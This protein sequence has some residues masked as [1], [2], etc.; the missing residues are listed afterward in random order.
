MTVDKSI[1]VTYHRNMCSRCHVWR[2][3]NVLVFYGEVC[4]KAWRGEGVVRYSGV[5]QLMGFFLMLN[6]PNPPP[7]ATATWLNQLTP[8]AWGHGCAT[9]V[10]TAPRGVVWGLWW[11]LSHSLT[12]CRISLHTSHGLTPPLKSMM[13]VN[14]K[15]SKVDSDTDRWT[16]LCTNKNG[17]I[18][19]KWVA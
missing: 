19:L 5:H 12:H 9:L 13:T 17:H 15:Q 2:N 11:C 3:Q 1:S 10:Q 14:L 16:L 8:Q 18:K 7:P 6:P 4:V